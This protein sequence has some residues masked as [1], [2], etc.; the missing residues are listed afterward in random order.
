MSDTS[1]IRQRL[2]DLMSPLV[3][4]PALGLIGAFI[5]GAVVMVFS[6]ANPLRAY[7]VLIQS[8]F[9]SL[10]GWGA[11]LA[12]A[13][14]LGL[15]GLGVAVAFKGKVISIGAEGQIYMGALGATFVGL[16]LGPLPSL[17]GIP[18]GLAAGFLV[19]GLWGGFAAFLS[20]RFRANEIIITLMLNYIAIQFAGFLISGPWRDPNYT[21]PFTAVINEGVQL[22]I[23]IPGTRLHAGIVVMV[24]AVA[25]VWW[26]MN[27]TVL[28]YQLTVKGSNNGAAQFA[29]MNTKR[30]V[31]ISMF[32]SGGLCG[33]A[34]VSELAGVQHRMIE[35]LSPGFGFTAV[36]ISLLAGHRPIG[37]LI[38]SILFGGLSI[39]VRGMQQMEG[40]PLAAAE[41]LQGLILLG[42]IA[43]IMVGLR[44]QMIDQKKRAGA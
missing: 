5:L 19:G 44:R 22:P 43:G 30:L 2:R 31:L 6:G 14:T 25:A 10:R 4:F 3:L 40:V 13:A 27:R 37:V 26:V 35:T 8:A 38:V 42:V 18:L 21:E 28:G 17:I 7:V 41:V 39:G 33:L 20:Q 11:T 29:G 15:A 1:L 34:G 36:A 12:R 9:G 23:V 16:F 24:V 32:I